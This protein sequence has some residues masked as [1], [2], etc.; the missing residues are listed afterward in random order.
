[1]TKKNQKQTAGRVRSS[2]VRQRFAHGLSWLKRV[3]K[4]VTDPFPL[5]PL[6]LFGLILAI[7][8]WRYMGGQRFDQV[9]MVVSEVV[10]GLIL[11]SMISVVFATLR[12]RHAVRRLRS[13]AFEKI[14]AKVKTLTGMQGPSFRFTPLIR[15]SWHWESP[16]GFDV[17][18]LSVGGSLVEQV[19]AE[20]RGL[21]TQITRRFVVV[22][23]LGLAKLA[24]RTKEDLTKSAPPLRVL[25]SFGRLRQS[26]IVSTLAGG[27]ELPHP[28]GTT[29]GD[30]F[31]LKRYNHGDPARL[32]V[33]KIFGRT[34]KLVVRNPE[35]A[36]ARAHSVA[37]YLVTNEHDEPAAAAARLA[38]QTGALGL[39]W[40]LGADG[41]SRDAH[42]EEEALDLIVASAVRTKIEQAIG[43]Q[44]FIKRNERH[45]TVRF[46]I[47]AP[48]RNGPWVDRVA[49]LA[50]Q[51]RGLFDA[52][53][54]GDGIG[55]PEGK[56]WTRVLWQSQLKPSV[57]R[58]EVEEISL[59][60]MS[61]GVRVAVLD[62][63]TGQVVTPTP[64][65]KK[66]K[67]A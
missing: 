48:A 66:R 16:D 27:D 15:I 64:S 12:L 59:K 60:L 17:E 37:A 2:K 18:Q 10:V 4:R 31:E 55:K 36:L 51:R 19:T 58:R 29:E 50:G 62:R 6:G 8:G 9:L 30:R 61:C 53:I 67:V 63:S 32:I 24:F 52:I 33:W 38:V 28:L 40:V 20:K 46:M 54:V 23:S 13:E 35:K 22:D 11:L 39:Q 65:K 47:F 5:T 44:G 21:H 57:A 25:P 56:R 7:W 41:A 3:W 1:M 14:E 34:R 26:A 43:L 45:G 42:H 49:S